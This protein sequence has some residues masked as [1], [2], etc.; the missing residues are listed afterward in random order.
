MAILPSGP[1]GTRLK[2][3]KSFENLFYDGPAERAIPHSPSPSLLQGL[4]SP[5]HLSL[6]RSGRPVLEPPLKRRGFTPSTSPL[7][8]EMIPRPI[9]TERGKAVTRALEFSPGSI[10]QDP[11][12]RFKYFSIGAIP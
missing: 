11:G 7:L 5:V 1:R 8:K 10:A 4:H 2:V 12:R 3:Q 6:L 9:L